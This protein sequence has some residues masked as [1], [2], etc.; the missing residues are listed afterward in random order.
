V[1]IIPVLACVGLI[2]PRKRNGR[3]RIRRQRL[4]FIEGSDERQVEGFDDQ[5]PGDCLPI[6]R[7]DG[8]VFNGMNGRVPFGD[9]LTNQVQICIIFDMDYFLMKGELDH[10]Q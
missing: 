7:H 9:N 5:T 8:G 3:I 4:F 10:D 1:S 2:R 6:I